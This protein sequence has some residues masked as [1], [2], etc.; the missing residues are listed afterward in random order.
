LKLVRENS[1][2][3]QEIARRDQQTIIEDFSNIK[4][5]QIIKAKL[6]IILDNYK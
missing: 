5:E 2:N 6:E 1:S 3:V 4:I